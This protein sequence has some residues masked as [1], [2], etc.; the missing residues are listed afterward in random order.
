[1]IL[2][3]VL[4]VFL[5]TFL[6]ASV[7]VFV[8]S[9]F[10]QRYQ[11]AQGTGELALFQQETG[12]LK[13][14][15][16]SSINLWDALLARFDFVEGMRAH[17]AQAE[18]TWTVGRLTLMML[19]IGTMMLAF[20]SGI[21]WLPFWMI[22][23]IS[24]LAGLGPY[25]YVLRRRAKRFA[26]F[27]EA[28][29]EALE[30]MARAMRAGHPFGVS[31]ELLANENAPPLSTEIRIATEERRLGRSWEEA[32]QHL[33]RRVP[34]LSVRLFVAAVLL[35]NRTG[36]KLSE[37]LERLSETLREAVTLRGEIRAIAA[38]GRIT[39]LVLTLLPIGI[40]AMMLVVN[41]EYLGILLTTELGRNLLSAAIVA[42][43]AAHFVIQWIVDIEP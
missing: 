40:A 12:I 6:L 19:L 9:L 21:P 29:P 17:I 28:F 41:P 32:L 30:F 23:A 27:E 25:L 4:V 1:M 35:Q 38:H 8:A 11:Q 22:L 7:A 16:L 39:G 2:L 3:A 26:R 37:V 13:E 31:L 43:V 15:T 14:E 20:L 18:L 24:V 10:L 42:L 33:T 5:A 36:G 34:V